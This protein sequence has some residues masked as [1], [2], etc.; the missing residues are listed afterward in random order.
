M[1]FSTIAKFFGTWG[2]ESQWLPLTDILTF[3]KVTIICVISIYL[4]K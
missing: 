2:A 1:V 3:E 4:D